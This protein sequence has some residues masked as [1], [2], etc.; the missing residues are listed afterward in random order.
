MDSWSDGDQRENYDP[1]VA[2][3]Q[4][5]A[6]QAE[7]EEQQ[8]QEQELAENQEKTKEEQEYEALKADVDRVNKELNEEYIRLSG[9][10]LQVSHGTVESGSNVE[11]REHGADTEYEIAEQMERIR[12][13]MIENNNRLK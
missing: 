4:E 3:E 13:Q 8:K 6:K 11:K 9:I 7:L 5:A 10:R 2:A 12:E 1:S